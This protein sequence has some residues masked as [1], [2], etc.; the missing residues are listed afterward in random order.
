M[1]HFAQLDENNIVINVIVVNNDILLDEN[2][3]EQ[4]VNGILF[5]KSIY[6]IDTNWAQTSYNNKFRKLYA[7]LGFSYDT[8]K[9]AFIP[10]QPDA[11]WV[12]SEERWRWEPEGYPTDGKEYGWNP[13]TLSWELLTF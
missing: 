5:C 6:G 8:L 4:E 7:G 2:G 1:A 3:V 13:E 10:P 12:F 9:D 11:S